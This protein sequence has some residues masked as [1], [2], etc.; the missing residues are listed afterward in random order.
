M[1]RITKTI[2][3]IH[4]SPEEI[5]VYKAAEINSLIETFAAQVEERADALLA[6]A[7]NSNVQTAWT[8][9]ANK[10]VFYIPQLVG[11]M[12]NLENFDASFHVQSPQR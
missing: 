2:T 7:K 8:Y 5:A 9:M 6:W 1:S 3:K 4:V 12:P 11:V 10:D